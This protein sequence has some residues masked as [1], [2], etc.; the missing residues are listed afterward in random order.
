MNFIIDVEVS[1][2]IDLVCPTNSNTAC[3]FEL[4]S[5]INIRHSEWNLTNS[6]LI[7]NYKMTIGR[8]HFIDIVDND[9]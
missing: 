9:W 6:R 1:Y 2:V 7:Y 8:V 3:A 4:V 5:P